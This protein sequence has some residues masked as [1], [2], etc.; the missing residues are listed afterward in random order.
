L[1]EDD[2]SGSGELMV[3][4]EQQA[5]EL[6]ATLNRRSQELKDGTVKGIPAEEVFAR[7][8]GRSSG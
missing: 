2:E 8:R 7:L 6:V 3:E 1:G 4:P 5:E